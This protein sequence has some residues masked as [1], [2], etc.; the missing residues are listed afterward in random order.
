L[1]K[2]DKENVSIIGVVLRKH[3]TKNNNILLT[4]EDPTG[5]VNVLVNKN[6]PELYEFA[7]N[8]VTDEI[9]GV[10]GACKNNF[11]FPTTSCSPI[12]L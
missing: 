5:S 1:S 12:S 2:R 9:I 8:I 11:F 6:K 3:V 7:K 10:T 4:L